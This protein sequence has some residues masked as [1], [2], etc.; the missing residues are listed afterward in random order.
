MKYKKF[1]ASDSIII[2]S[3]SR[4]GSTWLMEMLRDALNIC[5]NWEPLHVNSG[6]VPIEFKLGWRPFIPKENS[7][8]IYKSL[9]RN[10]H[11][12]KIHSKWTRQY[13]SLKQLIRSKQVLVKYVRA[14]LLVPYLL[15]KFE[16]R[17]PP[18]FLIRHPID[19]CL[20]QI[21]AFGNPED[22]FIEAEIS[23]SL[24]NDRFIEHRDY[25]K[26]LETR[27]EKRIA[28]WCMNNCTTINQLKEYHLHIVFY[29]DLIQSPR[30]ELENILGTYEL[31]SSTEKLSEAKL[32]KA[33]STDFNNEYS[34]EVDKQLHKNFETL[35]NSE[36]DK[37][38]KI[39]DYFDFKLFTAYSPFPK[40][41]NHK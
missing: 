15:D 18:I 5:I 6:V 39:F 23:N 26:Q 37:I 33:S 24:N 14:N 12:F 41:E 7:D 17:Y 3:E 28:L 36:K 22:D 27:L 11:E 4:G 38:Q 20:S 10:I 25:I 40:K 30:K 8:D 35:D 31:S 19:T 1:N 21:K 2:F 34:S 9:F 16:F 13:L 32:R 29:S